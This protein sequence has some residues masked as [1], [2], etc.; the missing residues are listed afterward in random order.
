[1]NSLCPN[2]SYASNHLSDPDGRIIL[3]WKPH[4]NVTILHQSRQTMTFQVDN[5][6]TKTLYVTAVYAA[7][8]AEERNDLWIDL[9][10]IQSSLCLTD[11][12][13]LV[14]G[15]FN[16]ITHPAEHS[17][18]SVSTIT[19]PMS[20]FNSCLSQLE[21]R[22]LRY[23]GARFSW[24]NKC[25]EDPI[26]KKLDRA[27]I[28][29]AWLDSFPRSLARFLPP[30]ISDHTPCCI[31][32]DFPLPLAGTKPFKFFNYL[33][34]HPDFLALV[35][36]AWICTENEI[37]SLHLLSV[38]QKE[39]KREIKRLN[40][41][42][43]SQIQK[44]VSE[45]NVL[46]NDAQVLALQ[47]PTSTNFAAERELLAKL[48]LLKRV[49]EEYFKQLSRIN[50][51]KS[52]DLNT[53]YFHKVAKA[54]KAF[55][56]ITILIGLNGFEA[57]SPQDIGNLAVA[58]FHSILGPQTP[59]TTLSMI[60]QVANMIRLWW[61]RNDRLH[62]GIRRSPGLLIKKISSTIK[63]RISAMRPQQNELASDLL[64]LWFS[65]SPV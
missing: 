63:N 32:L 6:A 45:T 42:N 16:E 65:L 21:I 26:A 35:A 4:L 27:L 50:W 64:Q 61:E 13:W 2:W 44:R 33:T 11:H 31:T 40:K 47:Q 14:G 38:K 41:D 55:N 8:T 56:S 20:V 5:L 48:N 49:E 58:H 54:R 17:D 22:D 23:H 18:P 29:E 52:G 1:M 12:P 36:E 59:K 60:A 34:S 25:P 46:F 37:H 19:P 57:S 53:S 39:L 62:R 15:D 24:S 30:D 43:F 10:N 51:L 9:L 7:N 3:I 28:N